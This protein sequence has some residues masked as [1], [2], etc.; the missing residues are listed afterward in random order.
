MTKQNILVTG[1]SSG[2][3]ELIAKTL[4]KSGHYVAATMRGIDGKN[5]AQAEAFRA[6]ATAERVPL[7][8][9]EMDIASD[10]SVAEGV[11]A[12][13][14]KVGAIDV[15]VNNAGWGALGV[16]EAFTIEQLRAQFEVNAI[17][18]IRVD[19]AVLPLM[20][21]RK[22]GLLIHIT[23]TVGRITVPFF[24]P[25]TGAKH[26]LESM[27]ETLAAELAPFGIESVALA[28]G[29]FPTTQGVA[30][31]LGPDDQ[32]V[33]STWG[34]QA[35]AP[36][37]A[38]K[39]APPIPPEMVPNAQLIA[40]SVKALIDMAPGTRP[41]RQVVGSMMVAGVEEL[42]EAYLKSKKSFV[43]SM[44]GASS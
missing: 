4:A 7:D 26:A 13:H 15:V 9:L 3:G 38:F 29:M 20:R 31:A 21:A 34:T 12:V 17:G 42:N 33:L 22:S 43:D 40:D 6:W 10:R 30:N 28:P 2:F 8:V 14:D 18:P 32:A 44:G 19:K 36:I 37:E 1:T 23:S 35:T 27:S 16:L 41:L 39:N 5:E 11:K 24:G 25:Y